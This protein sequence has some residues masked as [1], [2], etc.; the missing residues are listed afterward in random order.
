MK[1]YSTICSKDPTFPADPDL[2]IDSFGFI[3]QRH[4]H[5]AAHSFGWLL[6]ERG[7]VIGNIAN[8]KPQMGY[9]P[10]GYQF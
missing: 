9:L 8:K 1:E 7:R 4:S 10:D 5:G 6:D 2:R 3:I